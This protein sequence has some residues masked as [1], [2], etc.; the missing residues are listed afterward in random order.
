METTKFTKFDIKQ[1]QNTNYF[2]KNTILIPLLGY[3]NGNQDYQKAKTPVV[4]GWNDPAYTGLTEK[5]K[6]THIKNKGWFGLRIPEGYILVD[7]DN[8]KDGDLLVKVLKKN[9]LQTHIIETPNGFQFF[10]KDTG[11][12]KNQTAKVLTKGVFVVDYRLSNKGYTVLPSENTKKRR[13]LLISEKIDNLPVW[14]EPL[15][16]WKEEFDFLPINE[17]ARNDTLFK[18][19]CR[20]KKFNIPQN[21]IEHL[22][23]FINENLCDIPL[24]KKELEQ[25]IKSGARYDYDSPITDWNNDQFTMEYVEPQFEIKNTEGW[26]ARKFAKEYKEK[27]RYCYPYKAWLFWNGKVWK[28]D[29]EGKVE[30]LCK[31]AVIELYNEV[32][33]ITNDEERKSFIKFLI[34]LDKADKVKAILEMAKSEEGIP[35]LPEEFD[36]EEYLLNVQ[37]GTLDL[38]TGQ[39]KKH[40]KED[41]LSMICEA[42]YN[43]NAKSELW[44]KFLFEVIPDEET[45]KYIQRVIG[46]SLTGSVKEEK[47]FFIFGST[48]TGKSTFLE[49]IRYI[50]GDY[51]TTADFETFLKRNWVSGAP[52]NDIAKLKN[53]RLVISLEVDEGRQLAEGLVKQLT[54]G[55]VIS[56]RPLYKEAIEFQPSFKLFLSANIRPKIKDDDYAKWKRKEKIPFDQLIQE[57]KR[58]KDLKKKLRQER[59]GIL[60]WAIQGCLEWQED[61]LKTPA[62]VKKTTEQYRDEMNP[63]K[64]FI[65]ECCVINPEGKIKKGVLYEKYQEYCKESGIKFPLGKKQLGEK[66]KEKFEEKK[67]KDGLYWIGISVF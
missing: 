56:A 55:D 47:L 9:N 67:E 13:F 26:F 51:A 5:E 33:K 31:K 18:H 35:I 19:T 27:I 37:N 12:V 58:D 8:K 11:M 38:R 62:L 24:D 41:Y 40:D 29:K 48:A 22:I 28:Q 34:G 65:L 66:I 52:R 15:E 53:K 39:L 50:L 54:G 10:F 30:R 49:T 16:R 3:S 1:Q 45:R 63:L 60:A 20:L 61:G 21:E 14:L 46:Y 23:T 32:S 17:G 36:K 64:D 59:E 2:L 7:I 57:K 44:E 25:I 4:R 6:E 42:N 43:E